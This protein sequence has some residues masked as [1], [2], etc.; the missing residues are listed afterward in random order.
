MTERNGNQAG[1]NRADRRE[2]G[3]HFLVQRANEG[4]AKKSRRP[5][6]GGGEGKGSLFAVNF[7]FDVLVGVVEAAAVRIEADVAAFD[8]LHRHRA[9]M[10]GLDP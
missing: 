3:E 8:A 4:R 7:G 10:V 2:T 6:R 9:A 1:L 5:V